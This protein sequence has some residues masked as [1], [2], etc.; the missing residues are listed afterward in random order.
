MPFWQMMSI[1]VGLFLLGIFLALLRIKNNFSL[2]VSV[3]MHGG[4][5]GCWFIVNNGLIEISKD[6][7]IWLVGPGTL[8]K[9]PLG[10]LYGITLLFGLCMLSFFGFKKKI[11][12][13]GRIFKSF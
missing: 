12:L 10:G 2:W 8:N 11:P 7:P 4:L 5:V 6:T 3:G 1:L 13:I 9:N